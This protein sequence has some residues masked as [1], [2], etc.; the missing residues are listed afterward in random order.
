MNMTIVV[1]AYR[2][3]EQAMRQFLEW[4]QAVFEKNRVQVLMVTDREVDLP[5]GNCLVYPK[6]PR[7]LSLPRVNNYGIKRAE[8]IVIKSDLDII[9]SDQILNHIS[10][11]VRDSYVFIGICANIDSLAEMDAKPW[12]SF[13][14]RFWG[15]GACVAMTRHDW[16]ALHG[17]NEEIWGWGDDD[18]ELVARLKYQSCLSLNSFYPLFHMNHDQRKSSEAD[19]FFPIR[20]QENAAYI[21]EAWYEEAWGEGAYD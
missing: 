9:F 1:A 4:N 11:V 14:K 6:Q 7:H 13:K 12:H 10:N 19:A 3:A 20:K 8:G 16:G 2:L 21:D 17:Y 15:W 18:H 5:Y